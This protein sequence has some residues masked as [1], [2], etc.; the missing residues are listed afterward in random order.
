[1]PIS[2]P[3]NPTVGQEYNT[4]NGSWIYQG[5]NTWVPSIPL[6]Y[7]FSESEPTNKDV[8][9]IKPSNGQIKAYYV[10]EWVV[11]GNASIPAP[12]S[13]LKTYIF[14]TTSYAS[15]QTIPSVGALAT[16]TPWTTPAI[17]SGFNY[18]HNNNRKAF[19]YNGQR[20]R[21]PSFATEDDGVSLRVLAWAQ[22]KYGIDRWYFWESTYWNNFQGN[23][24]QVN[25]WVTA[26]TFGFNSI[27]NA[28]K[29]ETGNN[30]SNGDGV[31]FYPG[32]DTQFPSASKGVAGPIVSLRMKHWRRGIQDM[33]YEQLARA[34]DPTAVD[35]LLSASVTALFDVTPTDVNDPTYGSR[36]I[37][38]ST[39]PADWEAKR[40]ALANIIKGAMA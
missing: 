8:I 16:W 40:V 23:T 4:A 10:N 27:V 32:T 34:I 39:N 5:N 3:T 14:T 28:S 21:S 12:S 38:W 15:A 11:T 1:M 36:D 2:P 17:V 33:D 18:L 30:Y 37:G 13:N 29:G 26:Q 24:G 7:S 19:Q 25:V 31:L 6:K 35:A 22:R 9:W 20:P